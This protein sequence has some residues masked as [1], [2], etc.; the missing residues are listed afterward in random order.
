MRIMLGAV[1]LVATVSM[2]LLLRPRKGREIR[3]IQLPGAWIVLGLALT[4]SVA[5]AVALI[6]TGIIGS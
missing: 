6:V 4:S 5:T 1:M 3:A 2:V